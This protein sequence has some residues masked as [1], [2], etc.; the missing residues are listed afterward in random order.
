MIDASELDF[1]AGALW[2][3][4]RKLNELVQEHLGKAYNTIEAEDEI[5]GNGELKIYDLT[6]G[7]V[8][9]TLD[10]WRGEDGG[11]K[12][13]ERWLARDESQMVDW[14]AARSAPDP[15]VMLAYLIERQILPEGEYYLHLDW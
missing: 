7:E 2:L 15:I 10:D 1:P 14:K 13:V 11:R 8:E 5:S 3:P 12:E 6:E 9:S 4:P